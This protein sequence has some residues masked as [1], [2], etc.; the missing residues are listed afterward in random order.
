MS[1]SLHGIG[2]LASLPNV[3]KRGPTQHG[4]EIWKGFRMCT[5]EVQHSIGDTQLGKAIRQDFGM[6]TQEVILSTRY[7]QLG[8][9][10]RMYTQEVQLSTRDRKLGKTSECEHKMSNSQHGIG[11]L[12]RVP[13]MHTR[14]ATL[15]TL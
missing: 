8:K 12:A 13:N 6:C 10:F 1:N 2:N 4:I 14:G 3:H 11:N 7:R 9:D 15:N 5:Q